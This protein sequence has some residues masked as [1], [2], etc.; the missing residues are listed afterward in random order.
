[1]FAYNQL[2]GKTGFRLK[3]IYYFSWHKQISIICRFNLRMW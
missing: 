3:L 2:E 1:L